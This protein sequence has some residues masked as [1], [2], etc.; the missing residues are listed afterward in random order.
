MTVSNSSNQLGNGIKD[1]VSLRTLLLAR[2]LIGESRMA[3]E[4]SEHVDGRGHAVIALARRRARRAR[5]RRDQRTRSIQYAKSTNST[6]AENPPT[7]AAMPST[8]TTKSKSSRVNSTG[9]LT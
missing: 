1:R 8:C 9:A 5:R 7:N 3:L 4:D 2:N 6:M